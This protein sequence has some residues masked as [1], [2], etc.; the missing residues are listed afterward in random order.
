MDKFDMV[1]ALFRDKSEDDI[2]MSEDFYNHY[3]C[4]PVAACVCK[5]GDCVSEEFVTNKF[6][7]HIKYMTTDNFDGSNIIAAFQAGQAKYA[8]KKQNDV[9]PAFAK[10]DKDGS[11]AID[12]EELAALSKELGTELTEQQLNDALIDLDLNKDGVV[13]LDEFCRWYFTGMKP[14]NGTRRTLLQL[15]SKSMKLASVL[16]EEAKNALL[17]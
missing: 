11:G 9:E 1:I 2:E 4:A 8:E 5:D 10:F 3:L 13:D 14:Y 16:E 6:G 15:G 12:K 17:S 7:D